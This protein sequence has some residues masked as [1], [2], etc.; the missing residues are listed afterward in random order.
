MAA[1]TMCPGWSQACA[2]EVMTPK[3]TAAQSEVILFIVF[4]PLCS[5]KFGPYVVPR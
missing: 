1:V 5:Y 2:F 3:K 4:L